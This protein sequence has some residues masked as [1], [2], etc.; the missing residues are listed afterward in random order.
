MTS[1]TMPE[2]MRHARSPEP[3]PVRYE[4]VVLAASAGGIQ[5]IRTI[6]AALPANF[7]LPIAVV[8]HR[9]AAAPSILATIL[10]RATSLRVKNAEEGDALERAT[11]YLAPPDAHLSI[12]ADHRLHVG[13]GRRI[14]FLRSSA[15]PLIHSAAHALHGRVIAV[16]LTGSG[17]NGADAL[18]DVKA[19]GGIVL[20]Q[21]QATSA[22]WGMPRAA[23]ATGAVSYVLP[24]GDIAPM[25]TK[26]S[27]AS[28]PA[29]DG[30]LEG[31][32]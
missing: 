15:D 27:T 19:L 26:L 20:A 18:R 1:Q 13:D 14:N 10:G 24:L 12:G 17:R 32:S 8:Q 29:V 11:V 28:V 9:S 7:P 6:L 4:L 30:Q 23:I 21:D 22:H 25:L 16:V 3:V 5:A 31:R 2:P